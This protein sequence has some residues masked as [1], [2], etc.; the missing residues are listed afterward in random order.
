MIN[1]ESPGSLLEDQA[2]DI[3]TQSIYFIDLR[4][5]AGEKAKKPALMVNHWHCFTD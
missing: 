5:S 3:G 1:Y 2:N 4:G